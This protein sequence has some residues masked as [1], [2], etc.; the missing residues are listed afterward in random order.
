MKLEMWLFGEFGYAPLIERYQRLNDDVAIDV[1]VADH[2][3]SYHRMLVDAIDEGSPPDIAAIEVAHLPAHLAR[4][5]DFHNLLQLGAKDLQSSY[6]EW[7][8]RQALTRDGS[9]LIG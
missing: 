4:P 3:P 5:Q 1:R 6:L 7:K 9:S 2:S 8:W